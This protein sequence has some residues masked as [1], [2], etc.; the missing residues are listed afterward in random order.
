MSKIKL[1]CI[2]Y[3]G[4]SAAV[5]SSWKKYLSPEIELCPIELSA[6]GR[7]INEPTYEDVPHAV[8]DVALQILRQ[9]KKDEPYA[10]LGH[11]MGSL[12]AFEVYHTLV[13]VGVHEPVHM[14]F[15]GR[16]APQD[17]LE[18]T[19][20]YK[21]PEDEFLKVVYMYGGTTPMIMQ[22]EELR[23]L[24]IP[25]LRSDYKLTETYIWRE[26]KNK[27]HCP[28]TIVNGENDL[29]VSNADMNRWAEITDN[30][31]DVYECKGDHFFLFQNAQEMLDIIYEQLGLVHVLK[32]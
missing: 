13:A 32:V 12:L 24:F 7:R 25:I 2:P 19:E 23:N 17:Q 4:A 6:H 15:S 31:C 21:A 20:F 14:F 27:I 26:H 5:Y 3:S 30:V 18:P 1:F 28:I 16:K 9:L 8:K 29:S 10:I 22:N 11:S